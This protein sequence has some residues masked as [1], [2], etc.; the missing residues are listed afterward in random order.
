M[1]NEGNVF[2]NKRLAVGEGE[3][4]ALDEVGR[5]IGR[6]WVERVQSR[7]E[8]V[9]VLRSGCRRDRRGDGPEVCDDILLQRVE[10]PNLATDGLGE[11][12]GAGLVELGLHKDGGHT[13]LLR[14]FRNRGDLLR[15]RL[16]VAHF[17]G[18]LDESVVLGEVGEGTVIDVKGPAFS[19]R[20]GGFDL[21][22]EFVEFA[23]EGGEICL[24]CRA[25]RI[26]KVLFQ[27]HGDPFRLVLEDA[28]RK[29][30]VGVLFLMFVF[31]GV[32]LVSCGGGRG[33]FSAGALK[34]LK[35]LEEVELLRPVLSITDGDVE[36]G[37]EAQA[38]GKKEVRSSDIGNLAGGR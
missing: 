5:M 8:G 17:N 7:I 34:K 29:P 37:F 9:L 16:A 38:S 2:K 11:G 36:V 21:R 14:L 13:L 23:S 18:F 28:G 12:G 19:G 10:V 24:N 30:H 20:E 4:P 33:A 31:M 25:G 26:G 1:D 35:P 27:D 3:T 32:G 6:R 15:R 22:V